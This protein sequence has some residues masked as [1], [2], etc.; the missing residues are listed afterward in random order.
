[1]L[2]KALLVTKATLGEFYTE[3][4][5]VTLEDLHLHLYR[6]H[7]SFLSFCRFG[8]LYFVFVFISFWFDFL[9]FEV[10]DHGLF[11]DVR[12]EG[13]EELGPLVECLDV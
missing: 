8:E 2:D 1:M 11:D 4:A 6:L 12:V 9:T 10:S 7:E 5:I 3:G 13:G